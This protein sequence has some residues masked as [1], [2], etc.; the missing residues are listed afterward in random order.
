MSLERYQNGKIYT[1]RNYIDDLVYIGSTCCKLSER[2]YKHKKQ[3][4][5]K[6]DYMKLFKHVS[7]LGGWDNFYIELYEDFPC[8]NKNELTK[9]E[10]EIIRLIGNGLNARIEGRTLKEYYI[11]NQDILKAKSNKNY[12]DNKEQILKK[13]KEYYKKNKDLVASRNKAYIENNKEKVAKAMKEY[14]EKNKEKINKKIIC[15]CGGTFCFSGRAR[16]L[17]TKLHKNYLDKI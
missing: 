4:E 8:K 1:I 17:K 15:E 11:D 14:Y 13:Q 10:G 9:R 16:H 2:F 3:R 7:A 5:Y 6:G 12:H